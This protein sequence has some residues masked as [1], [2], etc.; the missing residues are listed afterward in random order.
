MSFSFSTKT[1]Q[2]INFSGGADEVEGLPGYTK[3][4]DKDIAFL[5]RDLDF[6]DLVDERSPFVINLADKLFAL[7]LQILNLLLILL[8]GRDQFIHIRSGLFGHA[9]FR[10]LRSQTF[11][12]AHTQQTAAQL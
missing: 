12:A 11:F 2:L 9:A 7:L 6:F 8:N 4:F 1:G 3:I 10:E 5:G